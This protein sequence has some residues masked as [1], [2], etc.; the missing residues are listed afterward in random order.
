MSHRDRHQLEGL[1]SSL[2]LLSSPARRDIGG[3]LFVGISDRFSLGSEPKRQLLS[4][5]SFKTID[6]YGSFL[7]R[8]MS[9]IVASEPTP[10]VSLISQRSLERTRGCCTRRRLDFVSNQFQRVAGGNPF[11]YSAHV[12][13]HAVVSRPASKMLRHCARRTSGSLVSLTRASM[14]TYDSIF[15]SP[16]A[17]K[18]SIALLT[19]VSIKSWQILHASRNLLPPNSQ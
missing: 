2:L 4:I 6:K 16:F 19:A 11:T 9:G 13:Q 5:P 10:S 14:K 17:A 1:L 18:L 8:L 15:E 3:G 12:R 7:I